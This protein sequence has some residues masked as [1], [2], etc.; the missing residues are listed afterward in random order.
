MTG[1]SDIIAGTAMTL[2][3]DVR[4]R[5]ELAADP[6]QFF[7]AKSQYVSLALPM[8]SRPPGAACLSAGWDGPAPVGRSGVDVHAREHHAGDG[9]LHGASG[10]RPFFLQHHLSGDGQRAALPGCGLR[11]GDGDRDVPAAERG[12]NHLLAGFLHR[13]AVPSPDAL[14]DAAFWPGGGR[15][16]GTSGLTGILSASRQKSTTVPSTSPTRPTT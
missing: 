7:R 15:L 12:G 16:Y 2:I 13:R 3:N 11:P 10:I 14:A 5:E 6:A 8:L 4:W 9:N 1:W